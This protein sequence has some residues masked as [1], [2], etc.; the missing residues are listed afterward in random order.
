MVRVKEGIKHITHFRWWWE[1][2]GKKARR[3][4]FLREEEGGKLGKWGEKAEALSC[5]EEGCL[6]V[7]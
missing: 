6:D 2:K 5:F 7:F 4:D 3:R 1:G